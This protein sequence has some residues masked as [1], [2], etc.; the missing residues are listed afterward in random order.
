M[1]VSAKL[2]VGVAWLCRQRLTVQWA[3]IMA[4]LLVLGVI[5]HVTGIEISTGVFYLTPVALATWSLGLRAGL[6]VSGMA[7]AIWLMA[8]AMFAPTEVSLPLAAWNALTRVGFFVTVTLLLNHLREAI[9]HERALARTDVLTGAANSRALYDHAAMELSRM[10][11]TGRELTVLYI[12]LDGF[13][14]V[15]DIHGHAVG[16]EVLSATA[17]TM[18]DTLRKHDVVARLG[19]DEFVILMPET[20]QDAARIIVQ[21]L[22]TAL[23]AA[24][25]AHGWGVT[26]S[27]GVLTCRRP[28]AGVAEMLSKADVQMYLAKRAGK[29]RITYAVHDQPPAELPQAV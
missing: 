27:I 10:V 11:R 6:W 15:N 3:L 13:K 25:S 9:A 5:D 17:R 8:N 16:D 24:M 21:R 19:G 26:F 29:N 18:N 23:L 4:A 14:A 2:V 20:S 22:Q 1:T 12:D 7:G 28:P